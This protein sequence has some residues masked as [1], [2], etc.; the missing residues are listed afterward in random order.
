[1]TNNEVIIDGIDVGG[2]WAYCKCFQED[3][4]EIQNFCRIHYK[5]CKRIANC[6]YKQLQRKTQE[7]ENLKEE[8]K[9]YKHLA[10]QHLKDYFECYEALEEIYEMLIEKCEPCLRD[11][12]TDN[13][14]H[15]CD[16][17]E[18]KDII[19]KAKEQE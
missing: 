7:C 19:T 1:M 9:Q 5:T 14:C 8:N 6:Y 2:C 15:G 17:Q 4:Y 10:E 13:Y 18:M 3:D 12:G 16:L 11:F